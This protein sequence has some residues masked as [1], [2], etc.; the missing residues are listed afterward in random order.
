MRVWGGSEAGSYSRL[1]DSCITQLEA[2]GASRTCNESQEEEGARFSSRDTAWF[3]DHSFGPGGSKEEEEEVASGLRVQ[4]LGFE[5]QGS[6]SGVQGLGLGVQGLGSKIEGLGW[7]PSSHSH[8]T[9][10]FTKYIHTS[11]FT[12]HPSHYTPHTTHYTLHTGH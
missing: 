9:V 7:H 4:G 11:H 8:P 10:V 3:M 1:I 12:L 2:Q 6:G 5:V